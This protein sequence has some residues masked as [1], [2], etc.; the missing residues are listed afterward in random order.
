MGPSCVSDTKHRLQQPPYI[1]LSASKRYLPSH[2]SWAS[3]SASAATRTWYFPST[4]LQQ[5]RKPSRNSRT[6]EDEPPDI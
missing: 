1:Y 3:T 2:P 5:Q 6:P 4:K